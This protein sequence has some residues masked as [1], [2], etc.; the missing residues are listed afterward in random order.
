MLVF[1]QFADE[2]IAASKLKPNST[3]L[4]V[5]CGPSTLALGSR[6]MPGPDTDD[7]EGIGRSAV[8]REGKACVG[9]AGRDTAYA[10]EA[11]DFGCLVGGGGEM[12]KHFTQSRG[13]QCI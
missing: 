2:A 10:E 8:A 7:E 5:A 12:I 11:A 4:D 13:S 9:L 1:E 6:S 3:V